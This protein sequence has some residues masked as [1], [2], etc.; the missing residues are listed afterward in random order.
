MQIEI[1]SHSFT[2]FD[3]EPDQ[4]IGPPSHISIK[5]AR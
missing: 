4:Y 5:S 2:Q 1:K 3:I